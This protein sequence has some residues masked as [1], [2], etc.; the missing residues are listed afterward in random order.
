MRHILGLSTVG[1]LAFV[2][3]SASKAD[4]QDQARAIVDKAI[5]AMGG[6][7]KLGKFKNQTWSAKGTYYGMGDGVPFTAN[8]AISLPDKFRF[9]VEGFMIVV[10][11]GDKGWRQLMG[12]TQEM[13][14]EQLANQK[15]DLYVGQV[16]SLL[17]LSDKAYTLTLLGET[18]VE[19]K[20]AVGVKVTH[21]DR[22]EVKLYFDKENGLLVKSEAK[23]K[24]AEEGNKEVNQ[25]SIYGNYQQV[26]GAW[27]AGKV[28]IIRDGKKFVE[29]ENS[30]WKSAEKLDDKL[31]SKP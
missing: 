15:D 5:K 25:E 24:S 6:A 7:E 30:D 31:F 18:K 27:L 10:F 16:A 14:K 22:P 9:E 19:D 26:D 2:L 4:D 20:P 12:E 8:Y 13:D 23:A 21:K 3:V 28:T 29:A 17:P 11:N 1:V